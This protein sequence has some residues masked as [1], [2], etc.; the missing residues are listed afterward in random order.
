MKSTPPD[1]ELY[2]LYEIY[3]LLGTLPVY[4]RHPLLAMLYA[5]PDTIYNLDR[6]QSKFVPHFLRIGGPLILILP[7]RSSVTF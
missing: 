4:D 5:T 1:F 2:E 7:S 3:E 6:N